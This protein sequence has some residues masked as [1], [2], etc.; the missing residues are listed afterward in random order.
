[1]ANIFQSVLGAVLKDDTKYQAKTLLFDKVIGFKGI[2]DGVGC[3][4][5]IHNVAQVL[6]EKEN[7]LVLVLDTHMLC[8]VMGTLLHSRSDSLKSDMLDFQEGHIRDILGATQ[9][10]KVWHVGMKQRTYVD[11][12]SDRDNEHIV[13]Q[14]LAEAKEIFDVILIDLSNE[15]TNISTYASLCC[16]KIYPV[17]TPDV[18]CLVN[19]IKVMLQMKTL[20]VPVTVCDRVIV[21][22]Q[23]AEVN[24][25]LKTTLTSIN[26]QAVATLPFSEDIRRDLALGKTFL[27][28]KNG[29]ITS[30]SIQ[31]YM[32]G[33]Q[34]IVEDILQGKPVLNKTSEDKFAVED[35]GDFH[36]DEGDI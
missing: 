5:I 33:V 24:A 27:N 13:Q 32:E 12:I 20:A 8:P 21:N 25:N 10:K 30:S 28:K 7:L 2:V 29:L 3:T 11:M 19:V 36:I 34:I 22:M 18:S 9:Y 16:D 4:S 35:T 23:M 6:A 31:E 15:P 17:I 14:L 26:L 1:M